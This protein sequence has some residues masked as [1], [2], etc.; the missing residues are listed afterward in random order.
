MIKF[1]LGSFF[2]NSA[3]A[4]AKRVLIALGFG[5]IST[6]G[7]TIELNKALDLAH[8]SYNSIGGYSLA[9]LGLSGCGYALGIIAGAMVF[10]VSMNAT[11]QL[12]VIP[13]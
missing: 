4:I 11:S 1:L 6:V 12:G 2:T 7:I 5:L 8:A 13:K 9:L 10:R 3:G